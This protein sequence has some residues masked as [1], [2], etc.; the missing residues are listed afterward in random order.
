[1]NPLLE[2]PNVDADAPSAKVRPVCSNVPIHCNQLTAHSVPL[3]S[4]AAGVLAAASRMAE[5][6]HK[7][8]SA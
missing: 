6:C 4:R 2:S 3:L 8:S 7:C 1:M 5:M